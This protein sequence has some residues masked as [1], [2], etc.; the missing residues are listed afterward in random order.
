MVKSYKKKKVSYKKRG[1]SNK[2][3][4]EVSPPAV[5]PAA[6]AAEAAQPEAAPAAGTTQPAAPAAAPEA[7]ELINTVA[8][9]ETKKIEGEAQV[10][11]PPKIM[12]GGYRKSKRR[13]SKKNKRRKSKRRK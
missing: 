12:E 2:A 5:P 1:G 10:V 8:K 7:I 6:P 3:T 4:S 13:N 9:Q 11:E